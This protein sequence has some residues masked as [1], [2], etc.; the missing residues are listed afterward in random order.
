MCDRVPMLADREAASDSFRIQGCE[1]PDHA[2]EVQQELQAGSLIFIEQMYS[3]I[4][5]Q[6]CSILLTFESGFPWLFIQTRST[7]IALLYLIIP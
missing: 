5:V 6:I 4:H 3:E 2:A 1:G 7:E